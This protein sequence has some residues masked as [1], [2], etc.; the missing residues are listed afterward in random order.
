MGN[1]QEESAACARLQGYD[2]IGITEMW[3]EG[4]Y[5]CSV[6]MEGCRMDRRG[7]QEGGITLYVNDQLECVE[8][9]LMDE[10]PTNSLWLR[11]KGRARQVTLH[12]TYAT[13]H[14]TR[15]TRWMRLSIDR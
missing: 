6:G 14:L 13:G 12:W 11:I 10:V 5:D 9:F 7:R 2:L 15:K 8:L 4:S 3:W 1:K